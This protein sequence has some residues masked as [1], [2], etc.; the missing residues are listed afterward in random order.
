MKKKNK[1]KKIKTAKSRAPK[2]RIQKRKTFSIGEIKVGTLQG[3]GKG[4]AFLIPDDGGDD[5]FVSAKSL[6][7][8]R[9]GDRVEVRKIGNRRGG[10]EAEVIRIL[11]HGFFDVVGTFDGK[12]I[13][14]IERGFGEVKVDLKTSISAEIGDRVVGSIIKGSNPIKCRITEVLGKEGETEAEVMGVIRSFNLREHFPQAV[15]REVALIPDTV[16]ER[17]TVGRRDFRADDTVT[18][19]GEHSKDFDDAICV[20]KKE[21]GYRLSVHIADVAHYALEGSA[22]DEEALTRGTSVYFA[23]RVL[24]M[25]PEKLSNGI[26]SLNEGVDRLTLSCIMEFDL[27]GELT[28][29]SICEGIIRSKARLTYEEVEDIFNGDKLKAEKRKEIL[30]ML[31]ASKELAEILNK[32]RLARGS[33]EFDI[34][35]CEILMNADGSVKEVQ[36]RKRLFSHKLIEEF[37]LVANETVAKHFESRKVPFVYRVHEAPPSEKVENLNAFLSG[38]GIEFTDKPKSEDYAKLI[39]NLPKEISG[40]VNRVALRSMSKAEYRA[41]NLGHFGLALEYYCHF[42]SPIRRYPDLAI[43]RIIKYCLKSEKGADKRFGEFVVTAS[44]ASS[45]C[46][47]RADEAERKVDDLLKAKFMQDKIG[48]E[49]DAII[50]G[51]TEWGLFA[52]LESGVEGMIRVEALKGGRYAFDERRLLVSNGQYSY[53]IGDEIRI[54]VTA[55]NGDKVAFELAE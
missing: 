34:A 18:I 53:R 50:S 6:N 8:A 2:K 48:N 32:R 37:M 15:K 10:G 46:E 38:L 29:H 16:L 51:V 4:Y 13:E 12:Y 26:C 49:Y 41:E 55:V 47:K 30:G 42:T 5:L 19:D 33:V 28:S 3:S 24:P 20:E 14:A 44:K 27:D 39:E 17:E 23:D 54:K 25:L 31:F 11:K 45:E 9:H 21:N 40:V 52:E 36:K 43:H 7:G 35:E 22:I 1:N